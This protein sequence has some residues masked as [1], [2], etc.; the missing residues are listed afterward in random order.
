MAHLRKWSA[1]GATGLLAT[2]VTLAGCGDDVDVKA[3]DSST[4]GAAPAGNG[5]GDGKG[6]QSNFLEADCQSLCELGVP[7][8]DDGNGYGGHGYGGHGPGGY[9]YGGYSGPMGGMGS[10]GAEHHCMSTCTA[11]GASCGPADMDEILAC[12]ASY[13]NP[14]CDLQQFDS[15]RGQVVCFVPGGGYD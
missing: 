13:L 2:S 1:I 5:G 15:C 4:G 6:G 10:G 3:N 7:C 14:T 9:G 12:A 11:S 8:W